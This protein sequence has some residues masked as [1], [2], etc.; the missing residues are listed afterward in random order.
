MDKIESGRWSS[1]VCSI[2]LGD[3][4]PLSGISLCTKQSVTSTIWC[5]IVLQMPT[6]L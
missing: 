1:A 3:E 4:D 6:Y 2:Y 5:R